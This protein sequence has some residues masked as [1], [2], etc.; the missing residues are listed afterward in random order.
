LSRYKLAIMDMKTNEYKEFK[1]ESYDE[2]VYLLR[3]I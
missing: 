2:L 1:T 3:D